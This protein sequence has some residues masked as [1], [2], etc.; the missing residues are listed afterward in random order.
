MTILP[1]A[2]T[3]RRALRTLLVPGLVLSGVVLAA[4]CSGRAAREPTTPVTQ[5]PAQGDWFCQMASAESGVWDCVQDAELARHPKPERLPQRP[6]AAAAEPFADEPPFEVPGAAADPSGV[7]AA[8]VD[9]AEAGMADPA[10]TADPMAVAEP[11]DD[12]EP[13]DIA[14]PPDPADVELIAAERVE[15]DALQ[16]DPTELA[17]IE[18]TA[19]MGDSAHPLAAVPDGYYALQVAAH[20]SLADAERFVAERQVEGLL[21]VP[22]SRDGRDYFVVLLGTYPTLADAR[23]AAAAMPEALSDIEPWVR[24]VGPL[25]PEPPADGG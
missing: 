4:G 15:A 2:G 21:I 22:G 24:P 1:S 23:Q 20:D 5:I 8:G 16:T 25:R 18:A 19:A 7:D 3:L 9:G 12:G 10:E 13:A 6:D 11:A 17:L 14:E